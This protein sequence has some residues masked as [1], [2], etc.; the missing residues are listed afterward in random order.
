[1]TWAGHVERSG[2]ERKVYKILVRKSKGKRPLG[3]SRRRWEDGFKMDLKEIGWVGC[4]VDS[5][6]SG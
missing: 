1:M 4:G 3:R 5:P 6:G 2:D